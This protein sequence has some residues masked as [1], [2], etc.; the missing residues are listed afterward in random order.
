MWQLRRRSAS[1]TTCRAS[2][3]QVRMH[4]TA[5]ARD[6][7]CNTWLIVTTSTDFG[8]SGGAL[9]SATTAATPLRRASRAAAGIRSTPSGVTVIPWRA[10]AATAARGMSPPPVPMSSSDHRASRISHPASRAAR[11]TASRA[12][13]TAFVPPNHAF[14]RAISC[15]SFPT[16]T[17]SAPGQSHR[18]PPAFGPP[19]PPPRPT[20]PPRDQAEEHRVIPARCLPVLLAFD[21]REDAFQHRHPLYGF[22]IADAVEAVGMLLREPAGDRLLIGG[23]HV[24]HEAVRGLERGVHV[25]V[26]GHGHEHQRRIE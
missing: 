23:E 10:A 15:S 8:A 12:S 26:A 4:R 3:S 11:S 18:P 14:S 17:G 25:V 5:C 6:M 21:A 9:A 22:A 2:R 20:R 7:W 1:T 19:F 16:A 24:E 13:T